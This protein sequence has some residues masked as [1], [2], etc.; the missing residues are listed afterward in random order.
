MQSDVAAWQDG[1]SY[2]VT[3]QQTGPGMFNLVSVDG[4][5]ADNESDENGQGAMAPAAAKNPA[6]AI[7]MKPGK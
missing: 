5:G 7:L 4:E 1:K 2:Q 3:I 6:V